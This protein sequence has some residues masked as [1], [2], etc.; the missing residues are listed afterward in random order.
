MASLTFNRPVDKQVIDP[1]TKRVILEWDNYFRNVATYINNIQAQ[2]SFT[3]SAAASK[4]V[5]DSR[6][7]PG[8]FI[9]IQATNAAA[10]LLMASSKALYVDTA[11][12]VPGVSFTV[13]T[14]D[15]TNAAGTEI[16]TYC[17]LG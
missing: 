9:G 14:R 8:S 4:V 17:I 10:A 6:V 16:F 15:G 7:R 12:A 1:N 2:G 3:L 11:S 13:K 5:T